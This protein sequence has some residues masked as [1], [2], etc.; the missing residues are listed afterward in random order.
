MNFLN[1]IKG[2]RKGREAHRIEKDSMTDPFLYEAIDGFDSVKDDHIQRID[3]L[4]KQIT[5][6]SKQHNHR[7]IWQTA[8]AAIVLIVAIGG[9]FLSDYHKT[10]L[11]AQELSS[12][13][14][15]EV[16]VPEAYYSENITVIAK[17][18]SELIKA[19]KPNISRFKIEQE[20]ISDKES[21]LI[22]KELSR[23]SDVPI[24]IYVPE[25]FDKQAALG[26]E[27]SDKKPEP[28]GGY[29]RYEEYLKHSLKRP[30]DHICKDR[31]GKVVVE[32]SVNSLGQPFLF[33]IKQSLCGTS[34]N[35]AIR[36]IQ[37]GPKWTAGSKERVRVRVIF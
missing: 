4:R 26:E 33:D 6:K 14:I 16:Y 35:E 28:I 23:E 17:M 20:E 2:N 7:H 34:D 31:K 9:Y 8:A 30:T 12:N 24:E 10:E 32:F 37:N 1:Y 18:N 27:Q 13:A 15:I 29:E 22:D 11:H 5:A 36:L 19:Y 25:D 3:D 21:R